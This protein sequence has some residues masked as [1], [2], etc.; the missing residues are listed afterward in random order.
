[1]TRR[2]GCQT[3]LPHAI[4]VVEA[5]ARGDEEADDE[6]REEQAW[7]EIIEIL[8][9][10]AALDDQVGGQRQNADKPLMP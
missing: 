2:R 4:G 6:D 7:L 5:A 1:M 3:T 9:A 8:A 10:A